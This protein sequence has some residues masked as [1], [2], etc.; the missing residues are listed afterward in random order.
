MTNNKF[1]YETHHGEW[2]KS[3]YDLA[4]CSWCEVEHA[5]PSAWNFSDCK[6]YWLYCPTC[7]AKMN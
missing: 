4:K 2:I 3:K 1:M 7:G 5:Y 6:K